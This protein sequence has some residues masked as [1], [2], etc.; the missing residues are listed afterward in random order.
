MPRRGYLLG[1]V[2]RQR[3][4]L[5]CLQASRHPSLELTASSLEL[6]EDARALWGAG[7]AL[8]A[9]DAARVTRLHGVNATLLE[10]N[11]QLAGQQF[12]RVLFTFPHSGAKGRIHV[13]RALL[14]GFARSVTAAQ[15][16]A[17]GGAVEVCLAAG[18]GGTPV[19]GEALR[20]APG[21][22]WQLG[23]QAAEGGLVL[24]SARE[25]AF[26]TR[27]CRRARRAPYRRGP[28]ASPTTSASG[29]RATCGRRRWRPTPRG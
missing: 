11:A 17:P 4:P 14:A 25:P 3:S 9:L 28:R 16:V 10:H 7:P 27:C 22:S 24:A 23:L 29:C 26:A 1:F 15:L 6:E 20:A 8:A 2:I 5:C 13:N 12:D 19:D 18:Q 21:D